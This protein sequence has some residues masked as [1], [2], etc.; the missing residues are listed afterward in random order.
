M[1]DRPIDGAM[2]HA[3]VFEKMGNVGNNGCDMSQVSVSSVT[4]RP[5]SGAYASGDMMNVICVG[6]H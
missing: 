3:D 4:F 2:G 5:A 6:A 1:N